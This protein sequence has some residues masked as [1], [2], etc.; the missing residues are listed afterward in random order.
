MIVTAVI[1]KY[2]AEEGELPT[3]FVLMAVLTPIAQDRPHWSRS[4][5]LNRA[6]GALWTPCRHP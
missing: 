5:R 1:E 3:D 4:K 2:L 6:K